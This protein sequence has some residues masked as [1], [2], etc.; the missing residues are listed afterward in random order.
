LKKPSSS[1]SSQLPLRFSNKFGLL[2][3]RFEFASRWLASRFVALFCIG[4]CAL[5][6]LHLLLLLALRGIH[7]LLIPQ[8]LLQLLHTVS[9][10]CTKS[11][12]L[13]FDASLFVFISQ[14]RSVRLL[15]VKFLHFQRIDGCN[16]LHHQQQQHA[17]L[18][19]LLN[20][21]NQKVFRK[22]VRFCFH[23]IWFNIVELFRVVGWIELME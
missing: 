14:Q 10:C 7:W 8:L 4:S 3:L 2:L 1:S 5:V 13:L 20:I 23:F 12:F 11:S 19:L 22:E 6:L 17:Q 9:S 16:L 15:V 21:F 18:R